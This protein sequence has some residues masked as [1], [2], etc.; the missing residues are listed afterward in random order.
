MVDRVKADVSLKCGQSPKRKM[1]P[2]CTILGSPAKKQKRS[3]KFS[4]NLNFWKNKVIGQSEV[5]TDSIQLTK[6]KNSE[7][8]RPKDSPGGI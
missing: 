4:E 7:V 8:V 1:K 5:P 2:D 3:K 6:T